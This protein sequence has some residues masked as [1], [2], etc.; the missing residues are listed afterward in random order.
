MFKQK[1][2]AVFF[3]FHASVRWQLLQHLLHQ[4]PFFSHIFGPLKRGFHELGLF[5]YNRISLTLHI[6]TH[7]YQST[8]SILREFLSSTFTTFF[9]FATSSLESKKFL[10]NGILRHDWD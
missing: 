10:H 1:Q 7:R 9:G 2:H 4:S 3:D 6:Y 8:K 5:L